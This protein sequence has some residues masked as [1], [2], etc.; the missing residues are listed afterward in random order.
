[1]SGSVTSAPSERPASWPGQL[2]VRAFE[3]AVRMVIGTQHDHG[4]V[5]AFTADAPAALVDEGVMTPAQQD[6][7]VELRGSALRPR[8]QV[9]NDGLLRGGRASREPA[10]LVAELKRPANG[11]GHQRVRPAQPER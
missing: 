1:M 11:R 2:I 9:V 5:A 4:A 6:Q 7:I 8:P 10:S 3:G